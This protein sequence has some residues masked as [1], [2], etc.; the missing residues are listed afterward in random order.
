MFSDMRSWQ[1]QVW[2]CYS[3]LSAIGVLGLL[4]LWS[5]LQ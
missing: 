5:E 2:A 3:G 4:L 1:W